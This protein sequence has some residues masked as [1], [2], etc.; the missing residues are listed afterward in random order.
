MGSF[1]ATNKFQPSPEGS[2]G[3]FHRESINITAGTM[4][5]LYRGGAACSA[6]YPGSPAK[7]YESN[8]VVDIAC[9]SSIIDAYI[10]NAFEV[11]DCTYKIQVNIP[12]SCSPSLC[13]YF[14]AA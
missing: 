8:A 3:S 12:T 6:A 13:R 4:R 7:V 1:S 9:D 11:S 10:V 14:Q 2:L 5:Q